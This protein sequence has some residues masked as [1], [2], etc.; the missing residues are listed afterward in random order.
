MSYAAVSM[1]KL[2]LALVCSAH[3]LLGSEGGCGGGGDKKGEGEPCTRTS[4]CMRDLVCTGGM[5]SLSSDGGRRDA[6]RA[7]AGARDAG[8]SDA[9]E[10]DAGPARD[11]ETDAG[12]DGG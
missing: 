7:D 2:A 10:S 4:Q 11:A 9:G 8:E 3:L 5:C 12:S 1:K 6:G